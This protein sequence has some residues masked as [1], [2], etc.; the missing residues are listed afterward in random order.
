MY[1]RTYPA[2]RGCNRGSRGDHDGQMIGI[3]RR[4]GAASISSHPQPSLQ[5]TPVPYLG[6]GLVPWRGPRWHPYATLRCPLPPA[7]VNPPPPPPSPPRHRLLL[8]QATDEQKAAFTMLVKEGRIE[9]VDNG[10]KKSNAL[11][12]GLI[13]ILGLLLVRTSA[14]CPPAPQTP[15]ACPLPRARSSRC[16]PWSQCPTIAAD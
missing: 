3:N 11:G 5:R 14:P 2:P 4:Q 12:L 10:C 6:F 8:P 16:G 1:L 15:P 9:F 13:L 7:F